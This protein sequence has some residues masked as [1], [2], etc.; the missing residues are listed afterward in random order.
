MHT[1]ITSTV[2]YVI[3]TIDIIYLL[4]HP[5]SYFEIS[6]QN[7]FQYEKILFGFNLNNY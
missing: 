1:K 7:K 2:I 6:V 4:I 3:I 5:K